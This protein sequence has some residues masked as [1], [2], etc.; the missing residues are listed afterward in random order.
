MGNIGSRRTADLSWMT[1][2]GEEN[3]T[4]AIY[5]EGYEEEF[6]ETVFELQGLGKKKH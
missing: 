5:Q 1:G 6:D 4:Y 3:P 2:L